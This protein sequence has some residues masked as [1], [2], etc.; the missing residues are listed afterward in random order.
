M[1]APALTVR[2][3]RPGEVALLREM[4]FRALQDAPEQFGERLEDALQRTQAGWEALTAAVVPPSAQVMF[5]AEV[6]G[7]PVGS[8]YALHDAEAVDV[9]RLGGMWVAPDQRRQGIG[10]AL[11]D[12][13]RAW[14]LAA[15]K[16]CLRL[17]VAS[18]FGS[19][20]AL[21]ER[22]GFRLTGV[23]KA[24]PGSSTRR[25]VEMEL[26]LVAEGTG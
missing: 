8:A 9:G 6:S 18:D 19:G 12:S 3:L 11:V 23:D 1:M 26:G 16:R 20:L 10:T 14:A 24:F 2:R 22:A 15:G 7:T 5:L 13:V 4:R 25:I 21:Y 17:W